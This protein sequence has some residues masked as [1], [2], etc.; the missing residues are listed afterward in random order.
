MRCFL[1]STR[2]SRSTIRLHAADDVPLADQN[3][4]TLIAAW[5]AE[6]LPLVSSRPTSDS[7]R[8]SVSSAYRPA[9]WWRDESSSATPSAPLSAPT[10]KP[11]SMNSGRRRWT[12]ALRNA[13]DPCARSVGSTHASL[14]LL[15]CLLVRRRVPGATDT[16]SISKAGYGRQEEVRALSTGATQGR[17]LRRSSMSDGASGSCGSQ[18]RASGRR[19]KALTVR[20]EFNRWRTCAVLHA[21]LNAFQGLGIIFSA[22]EKR[23]P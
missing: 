13:R 18:G 22:A 16:R 2:K 5:R 1:L 7:A 20:S 10:S 9:A 11:G 19:R 3:I 6:G 21:A 17:G 4:A 12:I 15:R 8:F 14:G 23:R